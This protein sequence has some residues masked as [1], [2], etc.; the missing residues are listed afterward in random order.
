MTED[1]DIMRVLQD[2]LTGLRNCAGALVSVAL[3][4]SVLP[5]V[6]VDY[7]IPTMGIFPFDRNPAGV[8]VNVA[9]FF[10]SMI[11]LGMFKGYAEGGQ[12]SAASG[13]HRVSPALLTLFGVV[14]LTG[15]A[16][17]A[18]LFALLLPGIFIAIVTFVATPV[19]VFEGQ[20]VLDSIKR[21]FVLTEGSRMKILAIVGIA[22]LA[23]LSLIMLMTSI[24]LAL[25]G[26]PS[27]EIGE[28]L[29]P[30]LYLSIGL[31]AVVGL[32]IPFSMALTVRTYMLLRDIEAGQQ[33]R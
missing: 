4:L 25:G 2:S 29:P 13:W 31:G 27:G 3:P 20:G 14:L 10:Y 11:C 15:L 26:V 19:V 32:I 5:A 28:R 1:F 33:G 9:S 30:N 22:A 8:I 7:I 18:G 17:L 23:A 12:T 24:Y 16:T 21:S 6:I